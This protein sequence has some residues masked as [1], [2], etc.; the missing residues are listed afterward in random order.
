MTIRY[1]ADSLIAFAKSLLERLDL[2]SEQV[3]PTDQACVCQAS[4]DWT[5]AGSIWQ[6]VS[7]WHRP[8]CLY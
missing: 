2:P 8:S 3:C 5:C 1:D 4:A 6:T 7:S